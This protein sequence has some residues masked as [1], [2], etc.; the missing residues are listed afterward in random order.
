MGTHV[1]SLV[2]DLLKKIYQ[3]SEGMI[4]FIHVNIARRVIL[5]ILGNAGIQERRKQLLFCDFPPSQPR[6]GS[7]KRSRKLINNGSTNENN[8]IIDVQCLH[9]FNASDAEATL[10][11]S[12]KI[13][14][15]HLN[16]AM[17]VF[18]RQLSLS[19]LR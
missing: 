12:T 10:V 1:E 6:K 5:F 14:E 13:F 4:P 3:S 9:V 2:K 15:N 7:T 8:P 17:L 11:Q 18:I 16:P 19:T